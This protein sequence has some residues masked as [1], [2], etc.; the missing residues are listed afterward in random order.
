MADVPASASPALADGLAQ[1]ETITEMHRQWETTTIKLLADRIRVGIDADDWPARQAADLAR[2]RR[3]LDRTVRRLADLAG[4]EIEGMISEAYERGHGAPPAPD[5]APSLARRVLDAMRALWARLTGRT[6]R[7][8]QAA[9][10]A[11]QRAPAGQ[12]RAVVQQA[13]NRT[14][15]RGLTVARDERGRALSLVP[16]A[17]TILQT[18]AGNAAMDG[19]LDRLTA[20]GEDLVRVTR[21][22]HPC[23]V[24]EPWED[25]ILSVTTST[26]YPSIA[27]ARRAGLWHPRCRHTIEQYVPGRPRHQ[28][29]I[30]HKP[31]T[32]AQEQRQRVIE[33]HIRDWKR[34][35]AAALDDVA[36]QLA[37]RKVRQ[38]EAAL[39]THLA[40]TGLQ[41]SRMRERID[42]GHSRPLRHA[43]GR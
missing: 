11:G 23:P 40:A 16:Q 2:I 21:S 39:R 33:R 4:P 35:E 8:H 43:L 3:D 5:R 41:R 17:E 1:V 6:A 36:A 13:L 25:R 19:Y 12:R 32:Y 34:R 37:R 26:E 20:E 10:L 18:A 28:H 15:D 14:A 24:C 38:W 27:T 9:I 42:F 30:D 31:G 29:A 7:A 22:P